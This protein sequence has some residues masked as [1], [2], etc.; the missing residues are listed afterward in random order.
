[1]SIQPRKPWLLSE[2]LNQTTISPQTNINLIT[3]QPDYLIINKPAGLTVHPG[4]TTLT[5]TTL[6]DLLLK[7]YP[8]IKMVG[9]DVTRPGIVHRLDKDVSGVMV[10]ARTPEMYAHLKQQFQHHL[11]YKQYV[12]IVHGKFTQPNGIINF[13]IQR[14]AQDGSK[15]AARPDTSGRPAQTDYTVLRQFQHYALVS[16]I[17]HTGRTHQIRVHLN[18]FG[19]PIIGDTV[20]RP[21]K[22]KTRLNPGR[23]FLHAETLKFTTLASELVAYTAPLPDIMQDFLKQIAPLPPKGGII[24]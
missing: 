9:E 19:H 10:I 8:E 23:I 17:I 14:S 20:Y 16:L 1:M 2:K 6:T 12:A 3:E 4:T 5:E 15:M 18:A 13:S 22:F 7:Q 11:I 24:H 21:K